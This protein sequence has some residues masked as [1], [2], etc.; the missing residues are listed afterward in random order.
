MC[1]YH[2]LNSKVVEVT[3]GGLVSKTRVC[4]LGNLNF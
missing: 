4:S 3:V 2:K 1:R